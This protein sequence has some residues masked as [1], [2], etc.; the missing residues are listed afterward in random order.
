MANLGGRV[1]ACL[2]ARRATELAELVAHH[3]G[4][5]YP[6]PCLRE[7]HEPDAA[8]THRAVNL[9]VGKDVGAA[10]FLTG[11]GVRTIA[12]AANQLR[13]MDEL[14]KS[15]P[16]IRVAARG[17]KTENALMSLGIRVD[18]AAPAPFTSDTLLEEIQRSWD[19]RGEVV[20]L[21][22]YG[23][24][25]PR[26]ASG[27]RQ[28]G[29]SVVEVS[30]YRW[31]WPAD[32]DA[33]VRLIED[34]REGWID[35]LVATTAAQV[36]NLF[37]IAKDHGSEQSLRE[38]LARP[39]T[40]VAA[41]GTVCARAFE[42][43]GVAV[44]LVPPHTSMSALLLHV[45]EHLETPATLPPRQPL[46]SRVETVA[47]MPTMDILGEDLTAAIDAV[48][49]QSRVT[50]LGGKAQ[51]AQRALEEAAVR[52]GLAVHTLMPDTK[53][54]H[55]SDELVRQADA[56]LIVT[57]TGVGTRQLLQLAHRYVKPVR[58]IH[59]DP[60]RPVTRTESP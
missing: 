23:A 15:M 16:A 41:Q 57:K 45:A 18:I 52:R 42:R 33:V 44:D 8:Q 17:P 5:T 40:L 21:Q 49:E 36:E 50:L 29:A 1:I 47:M 14:R 20:L 4:I 58:V 13:K 25:V 43:Q 56:V 55:A 28:M 6:A 51:K 35:V 39:R 31:E 30:P 10:V 32:R 9:L 37:A 19:L 11:V 27:L 46:S 12:E 24:P 3:R 53:A 2:E 60:Q 22:L 38:A 26:L 48:P 54:D 59:L 34:V 7:V